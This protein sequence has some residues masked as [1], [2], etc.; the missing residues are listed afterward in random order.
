MVKKKRILVCPL[1][2]GLGHAS[3]CIPL[4]HN[5]LQEGHVVIIAAAKNPLTLLRLEFPALEFIV[6]D[7]YGIKYSNYL[8]AVKLFFSLPQIGWGIYKEHWEVKRIVTK[9]K[10]DTLISDNR[11]GCWNNNIA[12]IFIS[13]QIF[14][15]TPVFPRLIK[16]LNFL[17]LAR[18]TQ[19]WIPDIAGSRN[20]SGELSHGDKLPKN[21]F[22][23]GILSRFSTGKSL[24]S[25]AEKSD[26]C[27]LLSGPEP[28]RSILEKMLLTQLQDLKLKTV[29]VRGLPDSKEIL[30][31]SE[32]LTIF[33]HLSSEKLKTVLVGSEI[34][35]CR[36]GYSSIMDLA[37]LGKKALF[38]PTPGQ[39]EQEYLARYF[40]QQKIC[41]SH[42]QKKFDLRKA[43]EESEKYAGFEHLPN[44]EGQNYS[45]L[46]PANFENKPA[47]TRLY[48]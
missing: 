26:L 15:K 30:P 12:S 24:P 1:D 4:I 43:L 17:F 38:I 44:F 28:Q 29:M 40:S 32:Q 34:V 47:N 9:Y 6:L 3:R 18:Y 48:M 5:L 33:N 14:I 8:F 7:G 42:A 46:L 35:I 22:Y 10:I 23:V 2:W 21:A 45:A 39:T 36:S 31:G 13:H 41:Y 16:K 20:L 27:I 11:Y 19:V 25:S 37:A